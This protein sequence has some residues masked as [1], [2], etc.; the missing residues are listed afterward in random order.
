MSK[1]YYLIVCIIGLF[2]LTAC[3]YQRAEN[4]QQAPTDTQQLSTA[5]PTD[6]LETPKDTLATQIHIYLENSG[7]MNGYVAGNTD[8]K[9]ALSDLLVLLKYHYGEENI[10]LHFINTEIY[11]F[12]SYTDITQIPYKLSP[13]SI[14]IGDTG[15]SDL[16]QIFN[17]ILEK[18]DTHTISI[19]LSDAIYSIQGSDTEALLNFQKSKTKDAFLSSSKRGF[20]PVTTIVQLQS[21]FWGNYWDKNNNKTMLRDAIRPYYLCITGPADRM[22]DFNANIPLE[23]EKVQGFQHKYVLSSRDFSQNN[24]YSVLTASF[25]HGRFKPIR[26]LSTSTYVRGIEDVE[27]NRRSA[28][29]FGFAIAV[30]LSSIPAENSYKMNPDNYEIRAGDYQIEAIIPIDKKDIHPSDWIRIQAANATHIIQIQ[31]KSGVYTDLDLALKK[32]IPQWVY[33]TDTDDDSNIQAVL[34]K[35]FGLK[36]MIEGIS[37]AYETVSQKKDYY[38]E[39]QVPIG[40]STPSNTGRAFFIVLILGVLGGLGFMV[41]KNRNR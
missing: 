40:K 14:A 8:F 25:N 9:D 36:Y 32:V 13:K 22:Q 3:Q 16:N 31:A 18:T 29:P 23:K 15:S 28:D 39:I 41:I 24:Y 21:V 6:S 7:S 30:D 5:V 20:D 12:F 34:D 17:Q 4:N 26:T 10:Q 27:I 2:S 11:P 37:E 35:T 1:G 19:L 33:H 38:F